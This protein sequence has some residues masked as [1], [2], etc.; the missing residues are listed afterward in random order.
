MDEHFW[1]YVESHIAVWIGDFF[2]FQAKRY[3]HSFYSLVMPGMNM[4]D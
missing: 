3:F 1:N 2:F 4:L